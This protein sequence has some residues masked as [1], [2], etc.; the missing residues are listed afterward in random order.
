MKKR[1]ILYIGIGAICILAIILAIYHTVF[2]KKQ[3]REN[4]VNEVQTFIEDE[5]VDN[6]KD[7]L[8]EFNKLFANKFEPQGFSV[9][10][11]EKYEGLEDKDLVYTLNDGIVA[12]RENEYDVNVN[13]PVINIPNEEASK[14]NGNTQTIF[15]DKT[16]SILND[17]VTRF[18]IYN[19]EYTAYLNENILSVAIKST[20]KEG[21][22]AQRV[23]VQTYNYDIAEN[24]SLTLNDVLEIYQIEKRT[25][26]KKIDEQVQEASKQAET[27]SQATGQIVYKRDINNSMYTT[28]NASNFFIGKDKQIYI[29]Y[30]YGNNN[31]TS[32]IDIIKV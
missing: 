5:P 21:N 24:K 1:N 6:P 7:T 8:A 31:L 11:V 2:S 14:L 13:I 22:S 17:G 18:T 26:N 19:V 32:E 16:T 27:I 29:I 30:A 23:I 9:E 3:E 28:D 4:L 15:A 20:L 25:V 10:G 12:E